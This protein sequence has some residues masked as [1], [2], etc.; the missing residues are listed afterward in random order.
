MMKKRAILTMILA[1]TIVSG[2]ITGCGTSK[3]ATAKAASTVSADKNSDTEKTKTDKRDIDVP[4]NVLVDKGWDTDSTPAI[5]HIDAKDTDVDFFHTIT[6][7]AEGGKGTTTVTLAQGT[8][9]MEFVSPL[10]HDGSAYEIF[11]MGTA[12]DITVEFGKDV[13]VDCEMKQIPADQVTDEMIQDIVKATQ[14]AIEK[15][16]DTLKGD[17]GKATLDKL[18]ENVQNSPNASD[19]TK[20]M[21]NVVKK[22]TEVKPEEPKNETQGTV[23]SQENHVQTQAPTENQNVQTE[24]PVNNNNNVQPQAPVENKNQNNT[25][26]VQP[27]VPSPIPSQP[28]PAPSAPVETKPQAPVHTHTWA[29]HTTS[30]QVWVSDIVTIPD[31]EIYETP[32]W[33]CNCGAVI[34]LSEQGTGLY[35][36]LSAMEEHSLNHL[37]AGEPDNGYETTRIQV[38][39][40]TEDLG[41]YETQTVVDYKYCTECGAKQ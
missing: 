32:V 4:I 31:Y 8:Y 10:N 34:D 37:L 36:D 20:D 40:H 24:A 19:D 35:A 3:D 12:Q 26:T 21:A 23:A 25:V 18:A 5:L 13:T 39:S 1:V 9:T 16:D 38:G 41:Y 27:T 33:A 28:T 15:G 2:V 7:D 6:P 17:A 29:D 11:D 30:S 14:N 22:E